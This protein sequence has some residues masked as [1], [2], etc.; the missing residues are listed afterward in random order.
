MIPPDDGDRIGSP[1]SLGGE[2]LV[3]R[4]FPRVLALGVIPFAE[5][6]LPLRPAQQLERSQGDLRGRDDRGHQILE[7]TEQPLNRRS[8]EQIAAVFDGEP[9]TLRRESEQAQI[10]FGGARPGLQDLHPETGE[11]EG[12]VLGGTLMIHREEHLEQG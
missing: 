10:E 12:P 8:L 1:R 6:L 4:A 3:D 5:Q 7:V 2:E 11:L 9:E